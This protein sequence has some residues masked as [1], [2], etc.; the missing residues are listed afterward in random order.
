MCRLGNCG[1]SWP[2]CVNILDRE[3]FQLDTLVLALLPFTDELFPP[4]RSRM[5]F[6][7]R[8]LETN[9]KGLDLHNFPPQQ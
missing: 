9:S 4:L 2:E 6:G 8:I 1:A 5:K 3:Q 7:F